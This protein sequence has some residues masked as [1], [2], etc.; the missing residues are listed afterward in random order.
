MKN[1]QPTAEY[2]SAIDIFY[3]NQTIHSNM[4][5]SDSKIRFAL[6]PQGLSLFIC[7]PLSGKQKNITL[8]ALRASAVKKYHR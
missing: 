1:N 2:T 7:R 6:C 4:V 3:G 8:C 5:P